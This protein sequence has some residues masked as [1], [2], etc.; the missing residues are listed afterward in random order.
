MKK[1]AKIALGV[2]GVLVAAGAA[3]AA[4]QWNNLSALRYG[5]TMDRDTLD[6]RLEENKAALNQAMDEYQISEYTFSNEE[7][8]QLTDGSMTAQEAAQ[9]LLEQSPTP[10]ENTQAAQPAQPEQTPQQGDSAAQS[11][12]TEQAEQSG[13]TAQDAQTEQTLT[14]EE[15]EIKELIA[16]MYV[17]RTTYVGKLDAVVQSAID[18][19]V[20]GEH[21]SE[22]RTKVVYSKMD[23]LIAMEKECDSKVAAV[24]SRLRELL[25]TTG[26]DD[27]LARQV[28]ETYR[29]EKSLKKAYYL[30]AFRNG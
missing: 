5:L 3:A 7:V 26:Q 8:A 22:N 29:E 24:V 27:T 25:K 18:E 16:T 12:Q 15:Q 2:V 23:E 10:S 21:T 17:L 11:G 1:G 28:E 20:A 13:Q 19:Y 30:N 4:W 6:Q 9:K 14:P